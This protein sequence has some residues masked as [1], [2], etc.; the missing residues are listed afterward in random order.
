[1]DKDYKQRGA[2]RIL[3]YLRQHPAGILVENILKYSGAERLRVYPVLFE[4]EQE[5]RIEVLEREELGA[6]WI[7]RLVQT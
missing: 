1:M 5:G 4:L 3:C 2:Q 7:V 6:A